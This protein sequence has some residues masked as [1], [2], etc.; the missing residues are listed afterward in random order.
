MARAEVAGLNPELISALQAAGGLTNISGNRLILPQNEAEK[1]DL[2]VDLTKAQVIALEAQVKASIAAQKARDKHTRS[3][4]L[5]QD[6][7]SSLKTEEDRL[8][9]TLAAVNEQM[10]N[11]AF[12]ADALKEAKKRLE[13]QIQSLDPMF[14]NLRSAVQTMST[15]I[16]QS[17]ADMLMSGK[18]N[19]DSLR[20]IFSNFV[21][22]MIAKAIEL[23]VINKIMNMAFNLTGSAAL[24][25]A[26]S[27]GAIKARASGGPV[28]VGE[29]GPELFI[30]NSAGVIRNN[31]DTLNMMRG[32]TQEPVV[33]Q[34]INVTTGVATTVRAE[35][36][37]MMPRIKS[38]TISAMIDGKKRGNVV[39][40]VF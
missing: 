14:Q 24:P 16:S 33:N 4:E 17:F 26:A 18:L 20:D 3:I 11:A 23:M 5:A 22:T 15:S 1:E 30:P 2:G 12:S 10:G 9:E 28:L 40:K 38:E 39:G 36:L 27:G 34:T 32:G 6:A 25:T 8:N 13:E 19:M 37:S 21:R 7:V 35:I 29:R 31:H